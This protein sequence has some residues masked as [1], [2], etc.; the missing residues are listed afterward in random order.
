MRSFVF[1]AFLLMIGACSSSP[2]S[3]S[4][5]ESAV[6]ASS[7]SVK[8]EE[9]SWADFLQHLPVEEGPILDYRGLPVGDQEKHIGIIPYDVGKRDLQQCADALM[10]LRAEY[11]F[12]RKRYDEIGFHFVGG[13][14]YTWN[15]YCRG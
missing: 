4:F 10:R 1:P 15:D 8:F 3:F 7:P 12:G 14:F 9:G 6:T 11:L 13:Q 2:S 5:H